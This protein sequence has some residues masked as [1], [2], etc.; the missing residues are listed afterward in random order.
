LVGVSDIAHPLVSFDHVKGVLVAGDESG[1]LVVHQEEV[2]ESLGAE[3]PRAC[4]QETVEVLYGVL[5]EALRHEQLHTLQTE[6]LARLMQ[7][8]VEGAVVALATEEGE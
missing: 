5:P 7:Q 1:H 2:V 3:A 6:L 4:W 8:R